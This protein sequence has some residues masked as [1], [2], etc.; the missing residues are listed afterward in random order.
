MSKATDTK[1][2]KSD[3]DDQAKGPS[4]GPGSMLEVNPNKQ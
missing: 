3:T 1:E 4:P 2:E